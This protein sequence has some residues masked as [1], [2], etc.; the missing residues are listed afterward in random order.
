MPNAASDAIFITTLLIGSAVTVAFTLWL[1][2]V[3][4]LDERLGRRSSESTAMT[5]T[6]LGLIALCV[7]AVHMLG[8]LPGVPINVWTV[9]ACSATAFLGIC[10]ILAGYRDSRSAVGVRVPHA[11]LGQVPL[12]SRKAA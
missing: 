5:R 12:P 1:A 9:S 7:S 4:S 10:T 11:E 8:L 3:L 6:I 2:Q